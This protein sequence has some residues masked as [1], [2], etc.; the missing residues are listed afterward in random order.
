MG[1]RIVLPRK[2][3]DWLASN[4]LHFQH[5]GMN[6]QYVFW[7]WRYWENVNTRQLIIVGIWVNPGEGWK[8]LQHKD[9]KIWELGKGSMLGLLFWF[10]G[11][12][13]IIGLKLSGVV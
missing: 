4:L 7:L 9:K 6:S 2:W 13:L 8:K 10:L 3:R 12:S 5:W 1:Y 11:I